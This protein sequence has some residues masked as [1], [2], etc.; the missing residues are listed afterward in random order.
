MSDPSAGWVIINP[1][2]SAAPPP[3]K[4]NAIDAA[5]GEEGAALARERKKTEL[6]VGGY[7]FQDEALGPIADEFGAGV[8][9]ASDFVRGQFQDDSPSF[10]SLYEE[11]LALRRDEQD[12]YREKNSVTS[13]GAN[14]L[15]G[16]TVGPGA[17]AVQ[18]AMTLGQTLWQGAKA[19]AIGGGAAGYAEGRGGVEG[20]LNSAA[21]GAA[22][23]A[24]LGAAIPALTRS[25]QVISRGVGRLKGLKGEG[26]ERRAAEMLQNAMEKDGITPQMLEDM[27]ATGKPIS[28]ADLGPSTRRLVGAAGRQ[29]E[30]G[31]RILEEFMEPRTEGQFGRISDDMARLLG[32]QGDDFSKVG[33][34]IVARRAADASSG[35]RVAYNQP[36]PALSNRGQAILK[37]PTGK[38]ALSRAKRQ[39]KDMGEAITDDAGNYTVRMLDQIQRA[40][41]ELG[42]VSKGQRATETA[43]IRSGMR[44]RFL[45]ELPDDLKSTMAQYRTESELLGALE[46]GRKF[47]RGDSESIGKSVSDMEG[48][49]LEMFRLGAAREVL[50]RMGGKIDSGDVSG[51]FQNENMR[52]RLRSIFPDP[53]SFDEFIEL[54]RIERTMQNTRNDVLKGSQTSGREAANEQFSE[55]ALGEAAMDMASNGAN[56]V[57]VVSAIVNLGRK[58]ATRYLQGLNEQVGAAVA[59][60]NVAGVA[61]RPGAALPSPQVP[62]QV[63]AIPGATGRAIESTAPA[64]GTAGGAGVTREEAPVIPQAPGAGWVI[65]PQSGAV[66]G[67]NAAQP[68]PQAGLIDNIIK[69]ESAGNAT[70]K[71]PR[72]SATGSGQFIE[73]TWLSMISKHRPELASGRNKKEILALRNDPQISREMTEA[74][75]S[76]NAA[77]LERARLPATDGNLYL[78]HFAGP[79]QAARILRATPSAPI[80]SI[81]SAKAIK[82]NPFLKGKSAGWVRDWAARKMTS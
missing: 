66:G 24:T 20:R 6:G 47:F 48:M 2:V 78:A 15:G 60:Q 64:I 69:A 76:E 74:Y 9:A 72:S 33:G 29:S 50:E 37:T 19:G 3:R 11:H 79:G 1:N 4:Y 45:A 34:E 42:D 26:A 22:A 80:S 55:S 10:G 61:A 18:G 32:V 30:D 70:A 21:V 44:D 62:G 68:Q 17:K 8:A 31:G 35:Y 12:A 49:E 82:A 40:M 73:K 52:R 39:M 63:P 51:M 28:L 81:M 77:Y 36:A 27:A 41:R 75:A 16:L 7:G 58:G 53:E 65:I 71:N 57:S 46:D 59:R 5:L 25:V 13:V 23:G 56:G 38:Q 14:V 43:G 54:A 67:G